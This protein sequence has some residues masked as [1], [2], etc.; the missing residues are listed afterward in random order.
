MFI[1]LSF[2]PNAYLATA[3]SRAVSEFCHVVLR[4]PDLIDR[5][6]MAAHELA[7]NVAKY[8][9]ASP[10]NL[11][12]ELAENEGLHVLIIRARNSA[13]PERLAEV[14]RRLAELKATDDPAAL[15]YHL[16]QES[17]TREGG[18][19]LGLARIR[20]ESGLDL[21]YSI[22]G[23]ELTVILKSAV[24]APPPLGAVEE[25]APSDTGFA[26]SLRAGA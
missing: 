13:A 21:D 26:E 2:F 7:E 8:S 23:N 22:S 1:R 15:Y 17:L 10:V 3:V 9:V 16:I 20:A 24:P 12:V 25:I 5:I 14:Q 6:H 19:G 4:D 11:E 18:S